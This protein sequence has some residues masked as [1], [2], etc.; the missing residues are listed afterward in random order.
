MPANSKAVVVVN[1]MMITSLRFIGMSWKD[2][3][4][5]SGAR[6][7]F[8]TDLATVQQPR[9]DFKPR[10]F[11]CRL[12]GAKPHAAIFD[13]EGDHAAVADETFALTNSKDSRFQR[14]KQASNLLFRST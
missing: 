8:F 13:D 5:R 1:I 12:I 14:R 2:R 11:R 7:Y 6:F 3:M 10:T 9:A 4:V